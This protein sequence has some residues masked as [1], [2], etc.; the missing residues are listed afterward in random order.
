MFGGLTRHSA[1]A[2]SDWLEC[3][4]RQ[5]LF[6]PSLSAVKVRPRCLHYRNVAINAA[7]MLAKVIIARITVTIT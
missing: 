6:L 4:V 3:L 1:G 7:T 5:S 2:A